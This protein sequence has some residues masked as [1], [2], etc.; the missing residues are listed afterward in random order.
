[1]CS[2]VSPTI[3]TTA[4]GN[5]KLRPPRGGGLQA[6]LTGHQGC[7]RERREDAS[8]EGKAGPR[9]VWF[10]RE[11][12]PAQ[13]RGAGAEAST[14][15]PRE[16]TLDQNASGQTSRQ[17]GPH[18]CGTEER[19]PKDRGG[20]RAAFGMLLAAFMLTLPTGHTHGGTAGRGDGLD[21]CSP[22]SSTLPF[23]TSGCLTG[24][25]GDGPFCHPLR[26][27]TGQGVLCL[28]S[29]VDA[30]KARKRWTETSHPAHLLLTQVDERA[31]TPN[32]PSITIRLSK[33]LVSE[34]KGGKKTSYRYLFSI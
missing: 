18:R 10:L 7:S 17:R 5:Q 15:E 31:R 20:T 13:S 6:G 1:M 24:V 8:D 4:R 14:V 3:I 34:G 33:L 22:A 9:R 28:A 25:S 30:N 16:K 19:G 21:T 32:T 12:Q 11:E 29:W 26:L 23:T 27:D 2:N